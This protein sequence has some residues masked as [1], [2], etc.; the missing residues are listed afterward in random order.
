M[1]LHSTHHTGN[2]RST[3]LSIYREGGILS[4]WRGEGGLC[5]EHPRFWVDKACCFHPTKS[6][7][8]SV[9][10]KTHEWMEAVPRSHSVEYSRCSQFA[11]F[12][13]SPQSKLRS[14]T[15]ATFDICCAVKVVILGLA[16]GGGNKHAG[17]L[18]GG[19]P[20]IFK[21]ESAC[22]CCC[23]Q[24]SLA[25]RH[26]VLCNCWDARVGQAHLGFSLL[27]GSFSH[28]PWLEICSGSP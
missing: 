11:E 19:C 17:M 5:V 3:L 7:G 10:N 14:I 27:D 20:P 25:L 9:G 16:G 6:E 2:M 21:S 13:A 4:F 28:L 26:R 22:S 15:P 12:P 1:Q 24:E 23:N 18:V 8:A